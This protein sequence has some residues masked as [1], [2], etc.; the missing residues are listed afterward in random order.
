MKPKILI[1]AGGTGGHVF[2]GLAV[3]EALQKQGVEV[4]WVGTR[5]GIEARVVEQAGIPI[6]FINIQGIRGNGLIRLLKAPLS[7]AKAFWQALKI[8]KHYSPDV[9]LTMGGYVTGPVGLAAWCRRI[10][11]VLHEQNAIFG[12]TNRLLKPFAN[13]TMVAFPGMHKQRHAIQVGNPIRQE[14]VS[15]ALQ[16]KASTKVA[17]LRVL[18]LGGSLGALALNRVVPVALALMPEAERVSVWHQTGQPHLAVTQQCYQDAQ[19]SGKLMPFVED[20]AAAY[21][22]A[23]IVIG[24]AGAL[25]IS[26]I[27]ALGL[28]SILVPYPFAVD[29][30]QT[31]NAAALAKAGGTVL[32]Q[33]SE[34]TPQRL[35]DTLKE[36]QADD[37]RLNMG[38]IAKQFAKPN[39]TKT[40]AMICLEVY[41]EKR[42]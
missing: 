2:P 40:V 7:I 31:A 12:L 20:M 14:L 27:T 6:Y 36:F 16:N 29:D 1:V 19:V 22:W 39:A 11:I 35:A 10:P 34:L 4:A 9:I 3:A 24:R 8:F 41:R 18:V 25:T 38:R 30:H 42:A 15:L 33:Q 37:F 28:P 5:Q 13:K 21:Q 17:T 23:D 32:I 26:E